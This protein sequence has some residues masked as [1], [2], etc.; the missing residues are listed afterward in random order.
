MALYRE[1]SILFSVEYKLDRFSDDVFSNQKRTA[2]DIRKVLLSSKGS[3][4][5]ALPDDDVV[6]ADAK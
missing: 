6:K 2:D 3:S 4:C 5:G 1:L